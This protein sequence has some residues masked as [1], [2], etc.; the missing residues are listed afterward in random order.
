M[1]GFRWPLQRLLDVTE[2]RQRAA[3]ARLAELAAEMDRAR[4]HM[5]EIHRRLGEQLADLSRR[6]LA[7]RID[8][9]EVFMAFADVQQGR[10]AELESRLAELAAR[11]EEKMEE[12]MQIRS[13]RKTL[14]RLRQGAW[15]R[16]RRGEDR[17][18]QKQLDEVASNA[19][20][21]KESDART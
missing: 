10:I 3:E 15:E 16:Y 20:V 4:H 12:Y 6:D 13:A 11:R 18:E 21:R 5:A 8:R 9:Q 14:R 7:E 1:G 17:M 19:F 2:Q